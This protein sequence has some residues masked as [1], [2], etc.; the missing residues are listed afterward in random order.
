MKEL[1]VVVLCFSVASGK[2]YAVQV[3]PVVGE[4]VRPIFLTESEFKALQSK[5][6][7][8]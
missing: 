2:K 8:R 1:I 5:F 4:L 6:I 7:D 3:E